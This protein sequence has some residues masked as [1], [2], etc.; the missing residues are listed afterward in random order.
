MSDLPPRLEESSNERQIFIP[1][2]CSSGTRTTV[3]AQNGAWAGRCG[4]SLVHAGKVEASDRDER[5]FLEQA[6]TQPLSF[7]E[8]VWNEPGERLR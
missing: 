1:I 3:S 6:T 4:C 7:Y 5:I 8:V 2:S